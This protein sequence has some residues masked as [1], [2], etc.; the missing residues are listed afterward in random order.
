MNVTGHNHPSW[1]LRCTLFIQAAKAFATIGSMR[2]HGSRSLKKQRS[3]A[4]A[5]NSRPNYQWFEILI[6]DVMCYGMGLLGSVP[7]K[8]AAKTTRMSHHFV[9]WQWVCLF[10]SVKAYEKKTSASQSISVTIQVISFFCTIDD[11]SFSFLQSTLQDLSFAVS[12]SLI[13]YKR[14]ELCCKLLISPIYITRSQ[15]CYE[16]LIASIQEIWAM[17]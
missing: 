4:M 7:P 5:C 14:P 9:R 11:V 15:L 10:Q 2:A 13:Q 16:L 3:K 8:N 6:R 1:E 17:L 12:F